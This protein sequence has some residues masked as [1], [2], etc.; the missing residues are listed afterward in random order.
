VPSYQN[1]NGANKN[2]KTETL[3]A[4]RADIDNEQW[5]GVPFYLRT[6]KRLE[7]KYSEIVIYFKKMSVNIFNNSHYPFFQNKLIIRLEPENN[8]EMNVFNKVPGL[9]QEYKLQEIKLLSDNYTQN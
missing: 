4:I 3:V 1:E 6:G 8:I 2:T 5:R 7:S 9:D